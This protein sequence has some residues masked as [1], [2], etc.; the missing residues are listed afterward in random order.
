M[1][2]IILDYRIVFY[3]RMK[4]LYIKKICKIIYTKL[5][6]LLSIFY[7]FFFLYPPFIYHIFF[8]LIAV[9]KTFKVKKNFFSSNFFYQKF[10]FVFF[11]YCCVKYIENKKKIFRQIFF[12]LIIGFR[13]FNLY[14]FHWKCYH[15]FLS[16]RVHYLPNIIFLR[17]IVFEL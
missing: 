14:I 7:F 10:F 2:N 9:L 5:P 6:L 8:F 11:F 13:G 12:S 15:A 3:T 16:N 1:W 4:Q 17:Q